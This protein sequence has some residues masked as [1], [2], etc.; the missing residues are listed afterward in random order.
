M[1]SRKVRNMRSRR[2]QKSRKPKRIRK[3]RSSKRLSK[4]RRRLSRKMRGGTLKTTG[5]KKN[6]GKKNKSWFSTLMR[7]GTC[8]LNTS[9]ILINVLSNSSEITYNC[10]SGKITS[11]ILLDALSEIMLDKIK[12]IEYNQKEFIIMARPQP[13]R[14]SGTETEVRKLKSRIN[15]LNG[16][17]DGENIR[18]VQSSNKKLKGTDETELLDKGVLISEEP[19]CHPDGIARAQLEG[20]IHKKVFDINEIEQELLNL[21]I[22]EMA[23]ND[24]KNL[25]TESTKLVLHAATKHIDPSEQASRASFV[26]KLA[27][28][29]N[30][31]KEAIKNKYKPEYMSNL[32]TAI[33][34]KAQDAKEKIKAQI[35]L[36]INCNKYMH[37]MTVV[38]DN[39]ESGYFWLFG[40]LFKSVLRTPSTFLIS[41][42]EE[43]LKLELYM[44]R[45][46]DNG[47]EFS[48]SRYAEYEFLKEFNDICQPMIN[49]M[50]DGKDHNHPER[51]I[52]KHILSAEAYAVVEVICKLFDILWPFFKTHGAAFDSLN[53]LA[54]SG[55]I[56]SFWNQLEI[57]NSKVNDIPN[58]SIFSDKAENGIKYNADD[59]RMLMVN[60]PIKTF[61]TNL[62]S[63]DPDDRVIYKSDNFKFHVLTTDDS[64]IEYQKYDS[65][66]VLKNTNDLS[67]NHTPLKGDPLYNDPTRRSA[68]DSGESQEEGGGDYLHVTATGQ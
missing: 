11:L 1:P 13:F 34:N 21:A 32:K 18:T 65:I 46:F 68:D 3:I 2:I 33:L 43:Y 55:I 7:R 9:D 45:L 47:W 30:L 15:Q 31:T 51:E 50:R 6:T 19:S 4:T 36:A 5:K 26:K 29:D 56:P 44:H 38:N 35:N 42:L 61:V 49:I 37:S 67:D 63:L 52:I 14:Q 48:G 53:A 41:T 17:S 58:W 64:R 27:E 62:L 8:K 24:D 22:F 28:I 23:Q 20:K 40:D 66:H 16:N 10:N 39:D 12:D 59:A 57:Q 54:L 25:C 60:H